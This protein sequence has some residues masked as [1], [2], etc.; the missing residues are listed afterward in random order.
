M[1][2]FKLQL[3]IVALLLASVGSVTAQTSKGFVVGTVEDQNNASIPN[4]T[5]K[6]TNLF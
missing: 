2:K 5:V 6:I 3:L 4:A 1:R